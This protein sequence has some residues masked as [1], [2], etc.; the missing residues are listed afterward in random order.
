MPGPVDI[1]QPEWP[2]LL[3]AVQDNLAARIHTS[4]PGLVRAYDSATQT[5]TVELAVQLL[6]NTVPPIPEVPVVWP[7]GAA[8]VLH[9]PLVAG[10]AVMVL[11]SE[12]DYSGWWASG[13]I[14]A[15]R[16][17]ARH[18]LHAVAI[19]GLR[20]AAAPAVVTGGHVTLAAAGASAVHLGSDAASDPVALA[21]GVEAAFTQLKTAL[22]GLVTVLDG[23]ATGTQAAWNTAMLDWQPNA[24]ATKVRAV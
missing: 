13:S 15:P 1:D 4:V 10:D 17:L 16:V 21:P 6:G 22:D 24:S 5:A 19:P 23:L 14:S 3:R 7:G 8:G 12:E 9:V 11:F 20:R 2:E 18:G